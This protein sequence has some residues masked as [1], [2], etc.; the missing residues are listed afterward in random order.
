MAKIDNFQ[1]L[2]IRSKRHPKYK[3]RK[4]I[5]ND[6]VEVIVQKL[7]MILFTNKKEVFGQ[8]SENLGSDLEKYLWKTKIAND[9][10]KRV[11]VRQINRFVPEL[12]IMGYDLEL[13]I[14]E[15]TVRDIM[16]VNFIITG[17]NLSFIFV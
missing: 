8:D 9:V 7:E 2:T 13:N 12:Q 5:E 4:V 1:D 11:I 17:Y 15:G 3:P 6:I 16:E 10:I 14:F